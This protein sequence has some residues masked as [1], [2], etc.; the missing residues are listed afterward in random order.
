MPERIKVIF[1][2]VEVRNDGDWLGPGEWYFKARVHDQDLTEG[3]R[4]WSVRDGDPITLDEGPW[5]AI[6]DVSGRDEVQ[7]TFRAFDEDVTS[8]DDMGAVGHV[9]RRPFTQGR[10]RSI[11]SRLR[12]YELIW[13]VQLAVDG[14]FGP[15][16]EGSIFCTRRNAGQGG[17]D[18]STVSGRTALSRIEVCPVWPVPPDGNMPTRPAPPAGTGF[19]RNE[20]AKPVVSGS[21]INVIPNPAVIPLLSPPNP[22]AGPPARPP[23]ADATNAARLEVTYY[24]PDSLGFADDDPRLTWEADPPANASFLGG[25]TGLKVMAWGR[26][27][28]DIVFRVRFLGEIAAEYRAV[29][30]R[31]RSI[32]F[33]ANILNGPGTHKPRTRPQDAAI[34]LA[35]ANRFLRQAGVE[36]VP[37]SNTT[38]TN[39]ATTTGHD[40]IYRISVGSSRTRNVGGSNPR[41]CPLNFRDGVLNLQ[42]IHS[43]QKDPGWLIFGWA[44]DRPPNPGHPRVT[45]NQVPT[46]S[47]MR[48]TAAAGGGGSGVAPDPVPGGAISMDLLDASNRPNYNQP[49]RPT[50]AAVLITND[51]GDPT[52][53][54]GARMYGNVIA[55]ELGHVLGLRHRVGAGPDQTVGYP[56]VQNMMCQGEPPMT[57]QDF[58]RIQVQAAFRSPLVPA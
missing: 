27:E 22:A 54:A 49:G 55:H 9:L 28:G 20:A 34:H 52:T 31:I 33:R 2:R 1:R 17:V 41:P 3:G 10:L 4:R 32:P 35:V 14:A 46:P 12:N 11:H 38:R 13:E 45:D 50:L 39:G 15:H 44:A 24:W 8:D 6:V 26:T 42:Y 36:L 37:D 47:W 23:R 5:S 40:G 43:I 18:F 30:R 29:V 53:D 19:F 51:C 57:R 56:P 16:P 58:D 48:P 21:D 7:V 25:N